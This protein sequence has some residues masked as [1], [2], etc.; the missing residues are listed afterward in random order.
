MAYEAVFCIVN[1]GYS[2]VVMDAAK[3]VGARGGTVIHAR[4]TANKE[5]EKYFHIT[6]QPDKDIVMILVPSEIKDNVLHAI[7]R[8][9][10]LKS[11]G[12]GIAFS[13]AVDKVVGLSSPSAEPADKSAKPDENA[14]ANAKPENQ[15]NNRPE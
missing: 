4:G 3:E 6:I 8:N 12:Q 10:G 15:E 2:D 5:A 13:M 7:Y 9:A 1:A 11:D 14:E